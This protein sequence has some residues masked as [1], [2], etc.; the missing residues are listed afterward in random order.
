[1]K[2]FTR[3][4]RILIYE[5]KSFKIMSKKSLNSSW[6]FSIISMF[7]RDIRGKRGDHF[8]INLTILGTRMNSIDKDRMSSLIV[9]NDFT[10]IVI[11]I[12]AYVISKNDVFII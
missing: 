11:I 4:L 10:F 8:L 1:M 2:S 12:Q 6:V 9:S 5:G 7:K 3:K